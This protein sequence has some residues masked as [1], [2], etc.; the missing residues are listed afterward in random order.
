MDSSYD[1]TSRFRYNPT[2]EGST[3]FSGILEIYI[4]HARNIHNICIYENQDVYAK[5]S[6]TYNPDETLS[7]RIINGGGKNP[8]FKKKLVVNVIH[9]MLFLSVIVGL[10]SRANS[11]MEVQTF[12]C[13]RREST[14]GFEYFGLS[15]HGALTKPAPIGLGSFS[16]CRSHQGLDHRVVDYE[17]V[18][19]SGLE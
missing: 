4:H 12:G 6:L 3:Q 14:E 18:A 1:Q 10:L 8:E 16:C 13:V 2:T 5:F 15:G 17:N 11:F 7:T 9:M 19:N